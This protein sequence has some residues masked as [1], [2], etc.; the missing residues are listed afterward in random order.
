M[1]SAP[2]PRRRRIGTPSL[3]W[4][5]RRAACPVTGSCPWRQVS[6]TFPDWTQAEPTVLTHLAPQLSAAEE[7][8]QISAWFFI[9]KHPSWRVRY[10]PAPE[11]AAEA[12]ACIEQHLTELSARRH[13]SGWASAVY[14]PEVHAFGGVNA[15]AA[16]HRLFHRDSL[17]LL[18]HLRNDSGTRAG[19]RREI[20][21]MLCSILMRA[22]RQDWYE[23]GDVWARV[24]EHRENPAEGTRQ[25]STTLHQ[26]VG[27]LISV[28]AESQMR[29]EASLARAALWADA[30]AAAGRELARLHAA[31]QLH[32]GMRDILAHHVIFAWNRLGLPYSAQ[33]VLSATARTVIFGPDPATGR[34]Q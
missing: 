32:R 3:P 11:A 13:I 6:I 25:A 21:L 5:D 29:E 15:M 28:D 1:P 12:Q 8:K 2:G 30:Y 10:L 14:E 18:A 27:R 4:P 23:Q 7:K 17:C 22:A 20:S 9:R 33:A 34:S 16:A 31:G 19:H 26:A 24:A